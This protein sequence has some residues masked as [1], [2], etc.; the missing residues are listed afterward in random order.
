MG[1]L[2]V[3]DQPVTPEREALR[4]ELIEAAAAKCVLAEGPC[5]RCREQ[6]VFRIDAVLPLLTDALDRARQQGR[7]EGRDEGLDEAYMTA[8]SV[9]AKSD[10]GSA[11]RAATTAVM[12]QIRIR[13][14]QHAENS[15]PCICKVRPSPDCGIKVHRESAVHIARLA[16]GAE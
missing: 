13:H 15:G 6:S 9:G 2:P 1:G 5:S 12:R 8:A 7:D 10:E 16:R 14:S 4:R 11:E 3:T